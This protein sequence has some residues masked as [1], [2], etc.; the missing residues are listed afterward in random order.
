MRHANEGGDDD[1]ALP[2]GWIEYHDEEEGVPYFWNEHLGVASWT[3]PMAS[4]K[5]RDEKMPAGWQAYEDDT[6]HVTYYYNEESGQT[7]WTHPAEMARD[8][9]GTAG[10]SE[11]GKKQPPPLPELPSLPPSPR[12]SVTTSRKPSEIFSTAI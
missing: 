4:P 9:S 2:A 11:S 6:T 7:T 10:S 3:R 8:K 1:D 5:K 12:A